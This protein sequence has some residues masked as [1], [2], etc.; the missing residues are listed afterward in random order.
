[1]TPHLQTTIKF[2]HASYTFLSLLPASESLALPG[3]RLNDT[4]AQRR[5]KVHAEDAFLEMPVRKRLGK[6]EVHL[7]DGVHLEDDVLGVFNGETRREVL[8][9][10]NSGNSDAGDLWLLFP[11]GGSI[12]VEDKSEASLVNG[13]T[14]ECRRDCVTADC[15]LS[16]CMPMTESL[17]RPVP[18][19]LEN[20]TLQPGQTLDCPL[21]FCHQGN[22]SVTLSILVVFREVRLWPGV[23]PLSLT[24]CIDPH[25]VRM[26]VLSMHLVLNEL[27]GS[28]LY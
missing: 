14:I 7:D 16:G 23:L 21:L 19:R 18:H 24:H 27:L 20:V 1:V 12:C 25:R 9:I 2:T 4:A 11:P 3:K 15:D 22:G 8:K 6:L 26:Q 28:S 5:A 13:E 17:D 10:T